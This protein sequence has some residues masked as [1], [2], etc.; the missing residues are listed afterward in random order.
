MSITAG[1]VETIS[2]DGRFQ[3][4]VWCKRLGKRDRKPYLFFV[5]NGKAYPFKGVDIDPLCTVLDEYHVPAGMWSITNYT[6]LVSNDC[7]I[8]NGLQ[9]WDGAR[10]YTDDYSGWQDVANYYQC[11]VASIKEVFEFFSP[12][13]AKR[14]TERENKLKKFLAEAKR[15]RNIKADIIVGSYELYITPD[16]AYI[17][18]LEIDEQ[19]RRKGIATLKLCKLAK[20]Y[21]KLYLCASS[22]G[23]K[24]L[25]S[26]LGRRVNKENCPH[27]LL[28]MYNK[29][30][31][32][33]LLEG[34][35][36]G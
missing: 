8:Y 7:K 18:S 5:R 14:I 6:L 33:Y 9:S 4:I 36:N 34:A 26:R 28:D 32:L 10:I 30:G 25:Y 17:G 11:D 29:W 22:E 31:N 27:D 35:S 15:G 3:K 21:G 1:K 16:Y 2:D 20:Q 19:Y 24:R 12:L 23:S 13:E